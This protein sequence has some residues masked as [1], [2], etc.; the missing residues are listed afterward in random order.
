[1]VGC[2]RETVR[3]YIAPADSEFQAAPGLPSGWQKARPGQMQDERY[4]FQNELGDIIE[5]TYTELSGRAGGIVANVN[6]WRGQVGLP[7]VSAERIQSDIVSVGLEDN[8]TGRYIS[9]T[10][11]DPN[12]DAPSRILAL[13]V[14]KADKT[15]F[16]KMT[17]FPDVVDTQREALLEF[18]KQPR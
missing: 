16:Y 1:M 14:P 3:T 6:R 18:A 4:L 15:L 13:V 8:G 2:G 11:V 9:L 7:E 10:G 17:G 12:T 5:M